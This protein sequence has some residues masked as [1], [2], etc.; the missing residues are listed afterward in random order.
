MGAVDLFT[1]DCLYMMKKPATCHVPLLLYF[2]PLSA[3]AV[4]HPPPPQKHSPCLTDVEML[5]VWHPFCAEVIKEDYGIVL[6][7]TVRNPVALRRCTETPA[8]I[9]FWEDLCDV[10]AELNYE[11]FMI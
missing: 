5:A 1:L 10:N 2:P 4:P 8:E 7:W 6:L 9:P 3:L 11:S